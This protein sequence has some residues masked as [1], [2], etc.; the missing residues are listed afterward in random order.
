MK[1]VCFQRQDVTTRW[2]STYIMFERFVALKQALLVMQG[3]QKYKSHHKALN[4][5]KERD[6]PVMANVVT[7]LKVI[8]I[9]C[10]LKIMT[11]IGVLRN[12]FAI[13]AL[14]RLPI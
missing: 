8:A 11:R 2:N 6:W 12:N 13:V 10:L 1:L 7:V 3:D 14:Q 5:I 4:K 9:H